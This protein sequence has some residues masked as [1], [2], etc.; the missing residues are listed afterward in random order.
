MRWQ[1]DRKSSAELKGAPRRGAT[2]DQYLAIRKEGRGVQIASAIGAGRITP[3]ARG[4]IVEL[5]GN[6]GGAGGTSDGQH[7]LGFQ[8]HG[9]VV[10][11]SRVEDARR[12]PA[13][14][15]RIVEFAD[16]RGRAGVARRTAAGH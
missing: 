15:R 8:P 1:R 2:S 3:R 13:V 5:A 16:R 4:R 14:R 9:G 10:I 7:L 12:R 11:A 6:G